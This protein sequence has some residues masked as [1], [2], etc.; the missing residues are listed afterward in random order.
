[1]P[2]IVCNITL[3]VSVNDS[4]QIVM[5][6]QG[7][8]K[9]RLLAVRLTDNGKP[10]SIEP[11][12]VVLLNVSREEMNAAY[13]GRV[14]SDGTALFVLPAAALEKEGAAECDVSVLDAAGGRLT[15][16]RFAVEVERAVSLAQAP[17]ES[18]ATDV[19]ASLLAEQTLHPL[20]PEQS[21]QGYVLSPELNRKYCVDLSDETFVSGEAW[22]PIALR[23][24]V[25]ESAERDLSALNSRHI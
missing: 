18:E 13:E 20:V 2:Q 19:I 22:L 11:D 5:A 24:P 14:Q 3:D 25:P 16:S 15:S 23:L 9:S 21:E 1:M 12:A 8:S 10:L 4:G 6:K 7:D 17:L